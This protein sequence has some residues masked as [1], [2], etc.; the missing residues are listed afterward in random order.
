[1]CAVV[2]SGPPADGLL[3]PTAMPVRRRKKRAGPHEEDGDQAPHHLCQ[4]AETHGGRT[5]D[6]KVDTDDAIEFDP[7]KKR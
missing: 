7:P 3:L 5:Q 6:P 4:D 2:L 1:L